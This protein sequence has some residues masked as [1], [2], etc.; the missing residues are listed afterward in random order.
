MELGSEVSP[1]KVPKNPC[2]K[3]FR[4]DE[5]IFLKILSLGAINFEIKGPSKKYSLKILDFGVRDLST[6][7]GWIEFFSQGEN[8]FLLETSI[9]WTLKNLFTFELNWSSSMG[10]GLIWKSPIASSV[11]QSIIQS[12]VKYWHIFQYVFLSNHFIKKQQLHAPLIRVTICHHGSTLTHFML[13]TFVVVVFLCRKAR[14]KI[15]SS[16]EITSNF[17]NYLCKR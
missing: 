6:K 1:P 11:L 9:Q 10:T 14:K 15:Q 16:A 5:K 17:I 8:C 7:P 2:E 12:S 4:Q 3:S 13:G